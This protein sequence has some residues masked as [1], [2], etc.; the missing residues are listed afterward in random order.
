MDSFRDHSL[1]LTSRSRY[2]TLFDLEKSDYKGWAKGLKAAGYA[3]DPKYPQKLITIIDRYQLYAID[4]VVLGIIPLAEAVA[5]GNQESA[6]GL[7]RVQAG[8]TLFA[9]SRRYQMS[10]GEL[11]QL[12]QLESSNLSIGQLLKVQNHNSSN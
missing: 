10:V 11:M 7:Y 1:F 5:E 9:I 2:A 12:N 4:A 8:D 6:S 3:T